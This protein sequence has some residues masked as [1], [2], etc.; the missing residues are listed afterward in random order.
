MR[1][2]LFVT[3]L[4]DTVAPE[5]GVAVVRL[6]ERLGHEVEFRREQ[7]CCGQMHLNTGYRP[8]ARALARRFVRI[9]GDAE[10]VVAPSASCV[11]TVRELYPSLAE[12]DPPSSGRSRRS[13]R[14]SS[15]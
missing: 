5:A 15:S 11:G 14:A 3:C 4:T 7:T 12:G 10:V 13:R 8:E 1:I 9:F 6:L 2:S